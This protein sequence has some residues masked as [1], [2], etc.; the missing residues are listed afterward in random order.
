MRGVALVVR[1]W[2]L[3]PAVAVVMEPEG[4]KRLVEEVGEALGG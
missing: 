1:G 3:Q 4:A 2:P